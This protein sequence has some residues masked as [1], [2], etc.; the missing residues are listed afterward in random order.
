VDDQPTDLQRLVLEPAET[1]EVEY[2]AWLDLTS[3]AHKAKLAKELIALANHGG[4]HVVL[5]FSDPA[6]TPLP[7]PAGYPEVTTDDIN[8]I[9]ASYSE[10]PFHC[11]VATIRGHVVISVPAGAIVPI[12]SKRDGPSGEIACDR[13]YIRRPGPNSEVPRSGFEWDALLRRC[14]SNR[15]HELEATVR[16]IIRVMHS[17]GDFRPVPATDAIDELLK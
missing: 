12:R 10:P 11:Q 4:G 15:D 5:G 17:P 1:L 8:G 14:I 16:R 13:Y 6:L 2:K 7:R 9:V 3:N